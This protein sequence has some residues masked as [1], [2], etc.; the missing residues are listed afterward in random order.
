MNLYE[1]LLLRSGEQNAGR[2]HNIKTDNDS[3]ER[4][5]EFKYLRTTLKNKNSVQKEIN[6]RLKLGD[7]C[8]HSVQ[9]VLSSNL[10][11]KNLEI[12]I[13]RTI[14]LPVVLCR[15]ETWSLTVNEERMLR[16]FENRML[17]RIF[18]PKRDGGRGERRKLHNEEL[19]DLYN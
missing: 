4:I 11:S 12:K 5:E 13:C 7:A 6:I 19:N 9:N 1:N 2:S 17:R 16:V 10:L 14:M 15:C 18:R 8:Y 3:F